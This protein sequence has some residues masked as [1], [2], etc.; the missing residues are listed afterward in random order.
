[1]Q[2]KCQVIWSR[3][4]WYAIGDGVTH[5]LKNFVIVAI[6]KY[7]DGEIL[8][9]TVVKLFGSLICTFLGDIDQ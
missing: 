5:Q 7:N 4:C 1:M 9:P 8:G 3:W 6:I 2:I